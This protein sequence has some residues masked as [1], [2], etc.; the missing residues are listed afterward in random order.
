MRFGT[1]NSLEGDPGGAGEG[2]PG[3]DV[4]GLWT[5]EHLWGFLGISVEHAPRG[6]VPRGGR[7]LLTILELTA[8][9]GHLG[10]VCL[11]SQEGPQVKTG[12]CHSAGTGAGL[13]HGCCGSAGTLQSALFTLSRNPPMAL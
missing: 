10:H 8:T 2:A 4:V 1:G 9:L 5:L 6:A 3:G 11:G 7:A 12:V 13:G